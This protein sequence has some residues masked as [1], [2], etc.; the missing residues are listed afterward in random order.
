MKVPQWFKRSLTTLQIAQFVVGASY[1]FLHLFV[2]YQSP[3]SVPYLYH[4]GSAA[5]SIASDASSVIS[6]ATAVASADFGAQAKKFFL[7]AAGREGLA[8]NV[9]NRQGQTFGVDAI[10]AAKDFQR[11]EET[12]YR[13]EL[14]WTHCLDTSGQA[15][16][17]WLN[18]VYLLP[19][20]WLFGRF[21][22]KSYLQ[23]LERKRDSTPAEKAQ[24]AI[25]SA[26]DARI[27][28]SRRLSHAFEDVQGGDEN[29][30]EIAVV[31][32]EEF[33]REV[34]DAASKTKKTA[35]P[36]AQQ[37][38]A[39]AN[40][41]A[42]SANRTINKVKKE[43]QNS[44]YTETI[45]EKVS[46][47]SETVAQSATSFKEEVK[48]AVSG[49]EEGMSRA[50]DT[51]KQ[52]ADLVKD[53]AG[54][55]LQAGRD[56]AGDAYESVKS[57]IPSSN[58]TTTKEADKQVS[59]E[60]DDDRAEEGSPSMR[61]STW[62]VVDRPVS[63]PTE[64][65]GKKLES[66]EDNSKNTESSKDEST[67]KPSA[68]TSS[69]SKSNETK[70]TE[71]TDDTAGQEHELPEDN[72]AVK[73]EQDK[74]IDESESVRDEPLDSESRDSGSV[75]QDDNGTGRKEE[76]KA[77]LSPKEEVRGADRD[78]GAQA[79]ANTGDAKEAET[80]AREST[81]SKKSQDTASPKKSNKENLSIK[82][83]NLKGSSG[84]D[85]TSQAA[86]GQKSPKKSPR[87]LALKGN[88]KPQES[89]ASMAEDK[90]GR[91]KH[92][93][94]ERGE[95]LEKLKS[96]QS[97]ESDITEPTHLSKDVQGEVAEREDKLDAQPSKAEKEKIEKDKPS[98]DNMYGEAMEKLKSAN[99]E[100]PA[101]G[102]PGKPEELANKKSK[103]NSAKDES[104]GGKSQSVG[105]K[106]SS[107]SAADKPADDPNSPDYDQQKESW[108]QVDEKAGESERKK[109]EKET[110]KAP[111]T[112]TKSQ[113]SQ[114]ED[115]EGAQSF[116]R[117]KLYI[118]PP[119]KA[120]L[121]ALVSSGE[122]NDAAKQEQDKI[123]DESEPVREEP[124]DSEDVGA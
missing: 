115:Q 76:E 59:N 111:Q 107:T 88:K 26:R 4:L 14:Q 105:A 24:L 13:D 79:E 70:G 90:E 25:E 10:N 83:S 72:E 36:Y 16:A 97:E 91:Q 41:A 28:T 44:E 73:K 94:D 84:K 80:P 62:D 60:A 78:E 81:T 116:E 100:P 101:E 61:D 54:S 47:A 86:S 21:F 120:S 102:D 85:F 8:E 74:I 19:L 63:S 75:A 15:F 40:S 58:D 18:V 2:E 27:R 67:S 112:P 108:I 20:A 121:E 122:T 6:T 22:V 55:L 96:A 17:I 52:Q 64:S 77:E 114:S 50:A 56:K 57:A 104:K 66:G 109:S 42:K 11:R 53:K 65:N 12:R 99:S 32:D 5:Q 7:R 110:E 123:I 39:E 95:A 93:E 89:A 92:Y 98:F 51:V 45:S 46:S 117:L 69:K 1:A 103:D 34:K 37:A 49:N 124:K 31:D 30:D 68:P 106:G 35:K 38:K 33:K 3:I 82:D 119:S 71:P 43:I 9:L 29:G 118:D 23:Q 87:K 113:N 48:K